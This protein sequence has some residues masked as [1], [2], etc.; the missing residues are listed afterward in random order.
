MQSIIY[1][2][3]IVLILVKY[4]IILTLFS[5]TKLDKIPCIGIVSLN[6]DYEYWRLTK[7][8]KTKQFGS[9]NGNN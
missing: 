4:V 9:S 3:W 7:K 6:E 8:E 2:Y 5:Q 1:N